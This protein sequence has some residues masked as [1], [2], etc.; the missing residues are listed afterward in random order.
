MNKEKLVWEAPKCLTEEVFF[1]LAGMSPYHAEDTS[2]NYFPT[3]G[4]G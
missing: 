4:V 3:S 2:A 1:T